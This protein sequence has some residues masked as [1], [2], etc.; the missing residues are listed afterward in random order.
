MLKPTLVCIGLTASPVSEKWPVLPETSLCDFK[1]S[2][3]MQQFGA[4]C[5]MAQD[6]QDRMAE[7]IALNR[8]FIARNAGWSDTR[9]DAYTAE[10]RHKAKGLPCGHETTEAYYQT[11]AHPDFL[12]SYRERLAATGPTRMMPCG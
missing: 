4:Q 1:V 12:G 2:I 11:Y 7:L 6:G 8:S 9:L 5:G 10:E 3:M